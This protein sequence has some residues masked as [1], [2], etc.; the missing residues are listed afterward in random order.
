MSRTAGRPPLTRKPNI[1]AIITTWAGELKLPKVNWDKKM[2]L[3]VTSKTRNTGGYETRIRKVEMDKDDLVVTIRDQEP[4]KTCI[5]TQ[6]T[7]VPMD[8]VVLDKTDLSIEW[9]VRQ[10][11]KECN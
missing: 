6:Q 10:E 11:V 4:G 8:I 9:Q 1:L 3:L 7:N 2:V 5:T